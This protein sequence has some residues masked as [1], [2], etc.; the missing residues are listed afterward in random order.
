[1]ELD[2]SH[3]RL[4]GTIPSDIWRGLPNLE[5][6]KLEDNR[7]TGTIPGELASLGDLRV[8]W[9]D[10]NDL[11]GPVPVE[12]GASNAM[13]RILSFN[14]QDNPS[15][16]GDLPQELGVDWRWQL[17]NQGG[18]SRDW[19]GFCEKDPCGIFAR[20]GTDIGKPCPAGWEN[21]L[22][23]GNGNGEGD[24][25]KQRLSC[26]MVWDQC[27]GTVAVVLESSPDGGYGG[28]AEDASITIDVP[29]AG[30]QC[31]RRGLKCTEIVRDDV[32][33]TS[34]SQCVADPNWELP[35]L[36]TE[37]PEY[38]LREYREFNDAVELVGLI[39]TFFKTFSFYILKFCFD[40]AITY[41]PNVTFH[42]NVTSLSREHPCFSS[43]PLDVEKHPQRHHVL[44]DDTNIASK[45]VAYARV[46]S[47]S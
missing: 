29:F 8:L 30:A 7:L 20:G 13:R 43:K 27:G 46:N 2:L 40:D 17:N 6:A 10:N 35:A 15:L 23:G 28:D 25:K 18:T 3:N 11:I 1:M 12:F 45:Y 24:D 19:F 44:N 31:C 4:S 26:G 16:C 5:Q 33:N 39:I 36:K 22:G 37:V 38:I 32:E 9:L 21:S 41:F 42:P 34:F 14:L 47:E